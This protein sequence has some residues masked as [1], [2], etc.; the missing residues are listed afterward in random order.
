MIQALVLVALLSVQDSGSR[1]AELVGD[2]AFIE[3]LSVA[4]EVSGPEGAWLETWTRHQ[5]GDLSGALACARLGLLDAPQ[6]M[7]LLEQAA[8]ICNSLM[9]PDEA[10]LY[11]DRMIELGDERGGSQR[12]HALKLMADRDSIQSSQVLS[13]SVLVCAAALLLWALRMGFPGR[14]L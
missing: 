8:Y 2:G 3:A 5:A 13:Y 10:L 12:D 4:G 11:A 14:K 1:V 9:L 7:R 6:D